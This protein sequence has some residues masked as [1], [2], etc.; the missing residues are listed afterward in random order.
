MSRVR[1]G[2]YN[3]G[4]EPVTSRVVV[5]AEKNDVITVQAYSSRDESQPDVMYFC[6]SLLKAP[7]RHSGKRELT[8]LLQTYD[9]FYIRSPIIL[10]MY[11]QTLIL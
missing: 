3:Y 5:E 8:N 9:T 11:T 4:L 2:P 6:I 1:V 10:V 7:S